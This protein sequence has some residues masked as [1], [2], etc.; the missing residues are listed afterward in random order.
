[1]PIDNEA[2]RCLRLD[3]IIP[4]PPSLLETYPMSLSAKEEAKRLIDHLPN[5]ATINAIMYELYVKQ[6]I[7]A[8]LKAIEEGRTVSHDQVKAHIMAR[9]PKL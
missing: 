9:H 8:R 1:M 5:Q 6:K 3:R 2:L 4:P 7:E